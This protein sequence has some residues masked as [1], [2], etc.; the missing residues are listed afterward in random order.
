VAVP[1]IFS[2]TPTE[3]PTT[4]FTSVEIL[5]ENFRAPTILPPDPNTNITP[6][7]PIPVK[8]YFGGVE[9][10]TVLWITENRLYAFTPPRKEQSVNGTIVPVDVVVENVDDNGDLIPKPLNILT[11]GLI[12]K[13][14]SF[15][16]PNTIHMVNTDYDEAPG[17]GLSIT[18]LA[19]LPAIVLSGPDL[20]ENRF[21]STNEDKL[22][23]IGGGLSF[24]KRE[25]RTVDVTFD[26][27][28]ISNSTNEILNLIHVLTEFIHQTKFCVF[29]PYPSR[30]D[31]VCELEF[32][33]ADGGDFNWTA[34]PNSSNIRQAKGTIIVRGF[35]F[36]GVTVGYTVELGES[37]I[38]GEP[39]NELPEFES[40]IQIGNTYIIGANPGDPTT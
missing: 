14:R 7:S 21:Y 30:P 39:G 6:P 11:R 26:I 5:G 18:H 16:H 12:T 4:G 23:P 2:I 40:L 19:S 38:P 32:G 36:D 33:F 37:Q 22:D 28:V 34:V 25:P 31:I 9:A 20:L 17:D 27:M 13:F 10:E 3:G 29:Q 8:V 15:V 35:D 24:V 1:T